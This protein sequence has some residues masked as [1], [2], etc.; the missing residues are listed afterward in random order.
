MRF[1]IVLAICLVIVALVYISTETQGAN[2]VPEAPRKP[3]RIAINDKL[4][5]YILRRKPQNIEPASDT[6]IIK[7]ENTLLRHM[8]RTKPEG[9]LSGHKYKSLK[10]YNI[11]TGETAEIAFWAN[12]EYIPGALQKLNH[13]MRDWRRNTVIKMDPS[14]YHLIYDLRQKLGYNGQIELISGHRSLAT[15]N[16]LRAAGGGQAKK[17]QHV[18]GTAADIRMNGISTEKLRDMAWQMQ[19]GGVGYYPRSKFVHV[20]TGRI[21]RW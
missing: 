7:N 15:N 10:L 19:R 3:L 2:N 16:A 18:L 5:E 4:N 6:K 17:S 14:L 13:F 20:D 1:Y 8:Q 11:N 21:R 12:G 9:L